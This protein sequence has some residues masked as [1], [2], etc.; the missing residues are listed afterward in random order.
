MKKSI[1]ISIT[2]LT[3]CIF[4]IGC[5]ESS[6]KIK[7]KN[8]QKN[9]IPASM[10]G[11]WEANVPGGAKWAFKIDPDGSIPK[12]NHIVAGE[13]ITK[14]G[15][16]EVEG[17]DPGT[18]AAFV[19]GPA[20]ASFEDSNDIFTVHILLDAFTMKLPQGELSGRSDDYF[21]GMVSKNGKI[22]DA[23]WFS[24]SYLDGGNMP[25]PNDIKN[26]PVKLKFYKLSESKEK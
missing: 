19:I 15:G 20:Q 4:F 21:Q 6:K 17:P 7:S 1:L 9:K 25:E 24:Y 12:L 10:V 18:Y 5:Q 14:E 26:N 16:Y 11:I 23:N 13:V 22:W 2:A 8:N 3:I